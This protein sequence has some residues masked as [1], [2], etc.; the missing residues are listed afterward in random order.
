MK[1]I[2]T[3]VL[4]CALVAMAGCAQLKTVVSAVTTSNV[5]AKTIY[6]ALSAFDVIEAPALAYVHYCTVKVA[7]LGCDDAAIQTK[8]I[9]ALDAGMAAKKALLP[10]I[11]AN[12]G[13]LG[14]VGTYNALVAATSTLTS[15]STLYAAKK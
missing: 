11:Q 13:A 7:P 9:P 1:K 4:L 15:F 3:S 6:V 5:P 10:I 8:I 14:P 2:L 12:H